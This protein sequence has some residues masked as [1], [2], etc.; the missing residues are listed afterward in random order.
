MQPSGYWTAYCFIGKLP[1]GTWMK[2][3]TER[4]YLEY[5]KEL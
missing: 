1:D 4:A 3:E 2:F 5:L